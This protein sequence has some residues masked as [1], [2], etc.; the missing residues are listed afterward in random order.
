MT[1]VA[2]QA[3]DQLAAQI[4]AL[5]ENHYQQWGSEITREGVA[6]V[7]LEAATAAL[8]PERRTIREW[9]SLGIAPA[10]VAPAAIA[11][12]HT[13]L[14]GRPAARDPQRRTACIYTRAELDAALQD[15]E[16]RNPQPAPPP[17]LVLEAIWVAVLARL[18]LSS[19]R[20]LLSQQARLL[21]LRRSGSGQDL[22]ALLGVPTTWLAMISARTEYLG[23]AFTA[24]MAAPVDLQLVELDGQEVAR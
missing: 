14:T 2:S 9:R 6:F 23:R 21:D 3:L 19:T 17:P 7:L 8:E 10:N 11:A 15:L 12:A 13:R 16:R 5:T 18:E 20:M 22:V 24:T 4:L 1:V